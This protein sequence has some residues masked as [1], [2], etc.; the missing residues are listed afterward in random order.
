[1]DRVIGELPCAVRV[2]AAHV[3]WYGGLC[4]RVLLVLLDSHLFLLAHHGVDVDC[5]GE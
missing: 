1:M 5:A 2:S 3:L 4:F